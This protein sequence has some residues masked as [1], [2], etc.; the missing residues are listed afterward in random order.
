MIFCVETRDQQTRSTGP[1]SR[2]PKAFQEKKWQVSKIFII[3][4]IS[5]INPAFGV[6]TNNV[7][8]FFDNYDHGLAIIDLEC[9]GMDLVSFKTLNY[10]WKKYFFRSRNQRL[11]QHSWVHL[12]LIKTASSSITIILPNQHHWNQDDC[13]KDDGQKLPSHLKGNAHTNKL[14]SPNQF[15]T[16]IRMEIPI[17][18]KVNS[19]LVRQTHS[20]FTRKNNSIFAK[21]PLPLLIFEIRYFWNY[22][23]SFEKSPFF[24]FQIN[25]KYNQEINN[26]PCRHLSTAII[27]GQAISYLVQDEINQ[28]KLYF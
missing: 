3:K 15:E 2:F 25:C 22:C 4:L 14:T 10:H 6:R 27:L 21:S 13:G 11:L 20:N 1:H 12:F 8:M 19:F 24:L 9:T 16:S 5:E 7:E 17:W 18:A 26:F 28:N 23:R